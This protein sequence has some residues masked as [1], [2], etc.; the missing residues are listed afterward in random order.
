MMRFAMTDESL[1]TALWVDAHLRKLNLEGVPYYII[2][3]G[4]YASG[5]VILKLNNNASNCKVFQQQRDLDN[6]LGWM[7]LFE[8]NPVEE[9]IADEYIQ[10]ALSNDPDL[11]VIEIEVK[12]F[13]NPF[14]GKI[15]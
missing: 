7:T 14:E 9:N 3:K 4:A 11:W 2:Q 12:E 15:F 1:P 13:D 5:T 10:R 8:D 6:T